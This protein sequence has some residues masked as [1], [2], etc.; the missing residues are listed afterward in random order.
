MRLLVAFIL[1]NFM[2]FS[3]NKNNKLD[4]DL[5]G[6]WQLVEQL[7]D[8]GDGSGKYVAIESEKTLEFKNDGTFTC[9]GDICSIN[10]E[11]EFPSSGIFDSEEKTITGTACMTESLFDIDYSFKSGKLILAFP[12]IEACLQKFERI[13]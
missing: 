5:V 10:G 4:K 2:V 13:E 7:M 8:P 3:C 11:S 1:V 6:K 9:N 12:C